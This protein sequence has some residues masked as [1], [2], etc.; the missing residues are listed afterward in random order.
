[1]ALDVALLRQTFALVI[2]RNPGLTARFY[3]ILFDKYPQAKPL[4]SPSGRKKQEAMLAQALVAVL[5]KLEDAPWIEQTLK[6]LGAKHKDYGVTPEMY[7]WVGA[8]LLATL[9]ETAGAD[10]TP[11]AAE[12]WGAAY[13]AIASLMLSGA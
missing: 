4:F 7:D 3:D 10:W 8:S 5:E 12:A 1:M 13:G 2:E 9:A 6:A 11:A